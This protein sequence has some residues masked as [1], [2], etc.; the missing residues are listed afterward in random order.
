[1]H[2]PTSTVPADFAPRLTPSGG[3]RITVPRDMRLPRVIQPLAE[4]LLRDFMVWIWERLS[5]RE[6]PTKV[7]AR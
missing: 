4:G 7:E 2:T 6:V 1:M 5:S 3:H